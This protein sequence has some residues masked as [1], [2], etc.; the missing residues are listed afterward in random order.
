[1]DWIHNAVTYTALFLALYFQVFLFLTYIGWRDDK[2]DCSGFIDDNALPSVSIMV[3]CYNEQDTVVRTVESLLCL[4]Y[5]KD[6]LKVIVINDGSTDATWE[7][8]QRF[9]D[10]HQ[11]VLLDKKNEGSKFAA[12]NFGLAHVT[13]EIVGC[14]DADSSVHPMAV[15]NSIEWFSRD[16]VYGVV[17]SMVIDHPKTIMQHMQKVEYELATYLKRVLHQLESLY[18]AP[19]PLTIF[20]KKVFDILGPYKEAHHTEDLEIALRM[21]IH[22]M[23]IVHSKDSLVYTKGPSNWPALLK[24]R[25]RWTYGFIKNVQD[26]RRYLFSAE[27]GDLSFFILPVAALSLFVSVVMFPYLIYG[28]IAPTWNLIERTMVSGFHISI[29]RLDL[30]TFPNQPYAWLG[31]TSLVFLIFGLVIGRRVILKER[32]FSVDLFT[33][34][35]YPFFASWWT[36]R[37]LWN[38]LRSKKSTWR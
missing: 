1:M 12:L 4:N 23:R 17:P 10:N 20:R 15:R 27:L 8:V 35:I 19:G 7:R 26:Y 38:A 21:Q 32:L 33:V 36:I 25:I 13:T 24:Q 22:G 37:S 2:E 34:I 11:V 5:P 9:K 3:P 18:V 14:L 28:L 16:D 29:P 30:F 6:K 31:Y